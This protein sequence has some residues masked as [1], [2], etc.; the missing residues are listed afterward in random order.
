MDL[1]NEEGQTLVEYILLLSI[2]VMAFGILVSALGKLGMEDSFL[3]PLTTKFAHAYQYGH[4]DA[5]GYDDG[6][7][8]KHP[9]ADDGQ[10]SFRIFK[11]KQ[12]N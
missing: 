1:K 5:K 8:Y 3:K 9:I 11:V 10:D 4:P 2:L 7:P 12:V 6:G